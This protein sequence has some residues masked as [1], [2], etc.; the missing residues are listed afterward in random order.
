MLKTLT[1]I[2]LTV[3]SVTAPAPTA[4]AWPDKPVRIIVPYAAGGGT[5]MLARVT[6]ERLSAA[7][8]QRFF[9]ENRPGAGGMIGAD[10]VAKAPSDGYTLLVSSPAEIVVNQHVYS[11]MGYDPLKDLAPIMLIAWTPL[12]I[13][14][15]PALKAGSPSELIALLKARPGQVS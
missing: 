5:D 11:K 14:A 12:I 9:V 1:A 13:T 10:A 15:H 4:H 2:A 7:L 6:A 8:G 3:L